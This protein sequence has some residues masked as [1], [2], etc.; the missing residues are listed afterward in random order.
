MMLI[1][2]VVYVILGGVALYCWY[3]NREDIK[4]DDSFCLGLLI[5][6]MMFWAGMLISR[7][8]G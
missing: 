4:D 1:M 7:W 6:S 3:K 2:G 5:S 8:W